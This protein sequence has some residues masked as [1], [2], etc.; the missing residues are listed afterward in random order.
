MFTQV[1]QFGAKDGGRICIKQSRDVIWGGRICRAAAGLCLHASEEQRQCSA[2]SKYLIPYFSAWFCSTHHA[3]CSC[4]SS[5]PLHLMRSSSP[6]QTDAQLMV[7]LT[8]DAF[9]QAASMRW[10]HFYICTPPIFL[11]LA[12]SAA[13][14]HAVPQDGQYRPQIC[15]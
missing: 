6:R 7:V 15:L 11:H 14:P 12:W 13:N 8:T 9:L 3:H 4:Y 2:Q 1:Q 5:T 10:G